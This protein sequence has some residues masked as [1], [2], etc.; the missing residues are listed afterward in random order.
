VERLSVMG[1]GIETMSAQLFVEELLAAQEELSGFTAQA[2][3]GKP[4]A[5]RGSRRRQ[6]RQGRQGRPGTFRR[7]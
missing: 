5:P 3:A 1:A 7:R 2:H 6:D 4:L